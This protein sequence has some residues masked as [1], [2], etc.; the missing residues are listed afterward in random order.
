MISFFIS[1]DNK[2]NPR[3]YIS[4]LSSCAFRQKLHQASFKLQ[5]NGSWNVENQGRCD[6]KK[7][8]P[9]IVWTV[10]VAAIML[11]FHTFSFKIWRECKPSVHPTI[12]MQSSFVYSTTRLNLFKID[13]KFGIQNHLNYQFIYKKIGDWLFY[14]LNTILNMS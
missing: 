9:L 4:Y 2:S 3:Y 12:R 6:Q 14:I 10:E 8:N 11:P 7:T 1:P 13:L 5:P